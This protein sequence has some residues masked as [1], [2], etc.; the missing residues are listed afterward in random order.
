MSLQT[1]EKAHG[2]EEA[3]MISGS[4]VAPGLEVKYVIKFSP[5]AKSDYNYDLNII[6]EREKFVVPIV[7]VGKRAMIDFPDSIN[8]GKDCPVKYVTE[9]P[10]IIRNL[11]DK[12]TKWELILPEGF[13]ADKKEGVLEFARSEQ[14]IL[15]FYPVQRDLYRSKALLRYD[16]ME[17][18][19]PITGNAINGNVFLS[20]KLVKMG[21]SYIG[22][23]N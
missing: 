15:K 12:T 21:E 13:S 9:K 23:E 3:P 22:L 2:G 19:I 20:K 4:K 18:T 14:I 5:E 1:S 17:A 11:G 8:F 7:A 6:T 16:N 10:V